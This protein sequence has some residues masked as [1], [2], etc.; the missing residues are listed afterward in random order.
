MV[1]REIEKQRSDR[2]ERI[3]PEVDGLI[4]A[5]STTLQR[6]ATSRRGLQ[7]ASG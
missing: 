5:R 4:D 6:K 7:H 2:I 3:I 1:E